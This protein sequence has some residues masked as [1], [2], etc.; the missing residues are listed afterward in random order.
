M[1]MT[2]LEGTQEIKAAMFTTAYCNIVSVSSLKLCRLGLP[3]A[4]VTFWE[5]TLLLG[6]RDMHISY[7]L[8]PSLSLY[9]FLPLSPSL[10]IHS[11]TGSSQ[12]CWVLGSLGRWVRRMSCKELVDVN[13]SSANTSQDGLMALLQLAIPS[14]TIHICHMGVIRKSCI[15]KLE[16]LDSSAVISE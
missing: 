14:S 15:W 10:P 4:T 7:S 11:S 5:L 6:T 9:S 3:L 2:S 13:I 1:E 12:Q 8:L 16:C